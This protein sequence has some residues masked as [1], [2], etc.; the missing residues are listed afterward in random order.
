M[1][2]INLLPHREEKRR[3]QQMQFIVLSALSLLFGAMIVGLV[4]VAIG[5]QIS[6][7]ERRNAYLQQETAVL[8]KQIA[9]I[10]DRKSVV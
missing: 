10:R 7:Q 3:A 5:A 6:Y 1:M 4:H 2:R 9:E 8:D